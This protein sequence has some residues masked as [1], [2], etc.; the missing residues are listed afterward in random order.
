MRRT[1]FTMPPPSRAGPRQRRGRLVGGSGIESGHA[2]PWRGE[3][4]S[5]GYCAACVY[6]LPYGL[7]SLSYT[8]TMREAEIAIPA[9]R[10]ASRMPLITVPCL[11]A[12]VVSVLCTGYGLIPDRQRPYTDGNSYFFDFTK[13][14]SNWCFFIW[15]TAHA[16]QTQHTAPPPRGPRTNASAGAAVSRLQWSRTSHAHVSRLP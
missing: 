4:E 6:A 12:P 9:S 3:R 13:L 7:L 11:L 1:I 16:H 2:I 5:T 8:D 10:M 14:P 15:R